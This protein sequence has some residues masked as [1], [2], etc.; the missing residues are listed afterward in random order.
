MASVEQ[1]L[2]KATQY[3]RLEEVKGLL[4]DNPNIDV[5]W[6][7]GEL[8]WAVILIASSNGQ[9][10]FVKLLLAQ[11]AIDV[12]VRTRD[13]FTPLLLACWNDR[14][15]VLQLLLKDPRVDVT[16]T[17]NRGCTPL[18]YASSNGRIDVL[19]CLIT[20]ERNLGNVEQK[21]THWHDGLDYTPLEIAREN[22]N[23]EM[24][25]LLER[26]SINPELTRYQVRLRLGLLDEMAAN[27]FALMIFVCDDLLQL[28]STSVCPAFRFFTIATKLPME[29][30]MLLCHKVVGSIKEGILRKDSESAFINLVKTL[31]W[32]LQR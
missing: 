31:H 8:G 19:E 26:F 2:V 23:I 4:R 13:G 17:D 27:V 6:K 24:A 14:V 5:N 29:L 10:D 25:P 15:P 16:L 12:N 22:T 18:F 7:G 32:S 28:K 1:Q 30:Q 11:S 21:G 20:S 3:D 9:T